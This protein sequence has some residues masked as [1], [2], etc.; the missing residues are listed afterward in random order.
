M[1]TY[2]RTLSLGYWW[3]DVLRPRTDAWTQYG[4]ALARIFDHE[5]TLWFRIA[6]AYEAVELDISIRQ[7]A[8]GTQGF[9]LEL[10]DNCVTVSA[11]RTVVSGITKEL[12]RVHEQRPY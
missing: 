12:R 8:V 6:R 4:D 1:A 7:R 10:A 9:T 2:E 3:D 5:E 11:T